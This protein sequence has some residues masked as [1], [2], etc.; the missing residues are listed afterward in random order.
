LS[1]TEN[2][3]QCQAT[4]RGAE[5]PARRAAAAGR[6]LPMVTFGLGAAA[7]AGVVI[8]PGPASGAGGHVMT[9]A[10]LSSAISELAAPAVSDTTCCGGW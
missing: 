6:L 10:A 1:A 8:V 7:L 3:S 5:Q 9:T 4:G 2:S